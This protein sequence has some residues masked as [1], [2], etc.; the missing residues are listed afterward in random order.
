MG[1]VCN[2]IL[3][4][5][6]QSGSPAL[7]RSQADEMMRLLRARLA[8]AADVLEGRDEVLDRERKAFGEFEIG[9]LKGREI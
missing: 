5:G 9:G 4:A 8:G 3:T 1:G 7:G 6:I 2:S